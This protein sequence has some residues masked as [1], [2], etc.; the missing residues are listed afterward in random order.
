MKEE[1][2]DLQVKV[3]QATVDQANS[4]V[5][6]HDTEVV[7]KRALLRAFTEEIIG[8]NNL[9]DRLM[10]EVSK[11]KEELLACNEAIDQLEDEK[12]MYEKKIFLEK[13]LEAMEMVIKK[14]NNVRDIYRSFNDEILLL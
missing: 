12:G 4:C 6:Q 14:Y 2:R 8:I 3:A 10:S 9:Y 5:E 11:P 7:L 13:M 1:V